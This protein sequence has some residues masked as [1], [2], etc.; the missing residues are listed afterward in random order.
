M[1]N[2]L[3]NS[4]AAHGRR[5]CWISIV[6]GSQSRACCSPLFRWRV[7]PC[8][9]WHWA[10]WSLPRQAAPYTRRSDASCG[11]M[12]EACCHSLSAGKEPLLGVNRSV[13]A[14]LTSSLISALC[15]ALVFWLPGNCCGVRYKYTDRIKSLTSVISALFCTS[16]SFI[17]SPTAC[18]S[19]LLGSMFTRAGTWLLQTSSFVS[20]QN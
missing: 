20:N 10:L 17:S 9:Y 8:C 12:Q 19:H 3:C 6:K 7:F 14:H 18:W 4:S 5:C 16:P 15:L 1:F 2:F 13:P 11:S